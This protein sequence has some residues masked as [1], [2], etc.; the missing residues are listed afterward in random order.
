MEHVIPCEMREKED[1]HGRDLTLSAH[2]VEE[3]VAL[4]KELQSDRIISL[5]L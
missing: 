2:H 3:I 4:C 1:Y 5:H